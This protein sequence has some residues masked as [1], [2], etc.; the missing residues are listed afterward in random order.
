[1]HAKWID[2]IFGPRSSGRDNH[3]HIFELL[4]SR[5]LTSAVLPSR[6]QSELPVP[7]C[8][9]TLDINSLNYC[10]FS[11]L[12]VTDTP[13]GGMLVAVP[14]T[15]D[16][17]YIDIFHFP[18]KARVSTAIGKAD[19][20]TKSTKASRAGRLI[21][22]RLVIDAIRDIIAYASSTQPLSCHCR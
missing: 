20:S 17:G 1:M 16:S 21:T 4:S 19:L 3:L 7:K 22:N 10:A 2:Q 12:P 9:Y 6:I 5:H 15:V 8:L 18:S 14:H 11:A 13:A